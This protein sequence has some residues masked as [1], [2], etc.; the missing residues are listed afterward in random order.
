[1]KSLIVL[2]DLHLGSG[3]EKDR[4]ERDFWEFLE[5]IENSDLVLLGDIF[6]FWIEYGSVIYKRYFRTLCALISFIQKG[7]KI[8]FVPGNHD[9]YDTEFLSNIG[10][11]VRDKGFHIEWKG[12]KVFFH[13][14][15]MFSYGGKVTRFFY[16]NPLTKFVFK[17]L[18]PDVGILVANIVSKTSTKVESK[19][20]AFMPKGIDR[21][22]DLYDIV[23]T[24]HTHSPGLKEIKKGKYYI[25]AG[26]WV[27]KRNYI[28]ITSDDL[29]LYDGDTKIQSIR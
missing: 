13:H 7:N 20:S 28:K 4:R 17:I 18:H 24:G 26:E 3:P 27:F 19:V 5:K 8:Y 16:G 15:D 6:D 22:F 14:G 25:N 9:F 21:L 11:D 29:T 2:S 23:I 10:F 1:M 12:K